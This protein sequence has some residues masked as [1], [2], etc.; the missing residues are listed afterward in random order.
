MSDY[1]SIKDGGR[2]IRIQ[3]IRSARKTS[4]LQVK[5]P[6][7]VI[8]RIPIGLREETLRR[9]LREYEHWIIQKCRQVQERERTRQHPDVPVPE[10]L[11]AAEQKKICEKFKNCVEKY[12]RIMQVQVGRISIRN[13][14][15]R[16]GSCSSKGNVNFN[17]RLY[18]MPE[19]L[20]DYVVIHELAHRRYMNH[21][22]QFWAEVE[23]YCPDYR[24][25]KRKLK[26]YAL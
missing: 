13:Q 9:F 17:Y 22:P 12:C 16:W 2:E 26:E 11:S 14:R 25:R 24:E 1:Y 19:E 5:S 8:A 6:N 20:L 15:T 4:A 18:Y 23:T 7:E 21:S 3:V 10:E